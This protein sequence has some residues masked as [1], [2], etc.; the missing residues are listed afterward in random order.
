[1]ARDYTTSTNVNSK[2]FLTE[3][4]AIETVTGDNGEDEQMLDIFDERI[5]SAMEN[6]TSTST[7]TYESQQITTISNDVYG[8]T[9]LF[10]YILWYNGFFHPLEIPYGT[11]LVIP[12]LTD[13]NN[14]TAQET[15]QQ[16]ST[17]S[18]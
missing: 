14:N 6:I 13:F 3:Y 17:V 15:S 11:E 10:W 9:S 18:V 2:Y 16:G 5:Q 4:M 8:N 7:V 1:M 12:S